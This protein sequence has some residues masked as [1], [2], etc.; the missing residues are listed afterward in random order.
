MS[1]AR[2]ERRG[3]V[4]LVSEFAGVPKPYRDM[5]RGGVYWETAANNSQWYEIY[6]NQLML[7]AM[8]RFR[9]IN[10]PESC[11]ELTLER[12]LLTEGRASIAVAPNGDFEVTKAATQGQLSIYDRP[13]K[14]RC[15]TDNGAR[16][17]NASVHTGTVV[18]E[19]RNRF[20][21]MATLFMYAQ[22]LTDI[23]LT[24]R[25]NR[26]HQRIPFVLQ[27]DSDREFDMTQVAKQVGG[28]EPML[29]TTDSFK[30]IEYKS[31]VSSPPPFLG[32]ELTEAERSVWASVYDALGIPNVIYKQERQITSE[33]EAQNSQTSI[34][35]LAALRERRLAADTLNKRFPHIF[36]EEP[37][38]VVYSED[39]ESYDWN[40]LHTLN[41]EQHNDG[42]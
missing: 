11:D 27:G 40:Q 22:E 7:L 19:N 26:F 30:E 33:V 4:S 32:G 6:L 21:L 15:T 24:K 25:V 20:P 42:I 8:N 34:L 23:H 9:W 36:G 37:I 29:L 14:W 41:K 12:L 5:A 13:V 1:K 28:G 38:S 18:Y 3:N 16:Q 10:L 2:R 35:R 31:L 39:Y 17:F